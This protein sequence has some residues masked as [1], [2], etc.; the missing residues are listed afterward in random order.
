MLSIYYLSEVIQGMLGGFFK[1]MLDE[2]TIEA[3]MKLPMLVLA[4]IYA[5]FFFFGRGGG[6][7]GRG[8]LGEGV[9]SVN[10]FKKWQSGSI[11]YRDILHL[12][13]I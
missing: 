2:T 10:H 12:M 6:G 3:A 9:V 11:Q 1:L 4:E 8:G 7:G 13:Y 5:F